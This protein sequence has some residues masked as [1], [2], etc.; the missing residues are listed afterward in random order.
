M[1]ITFQS[2]IKIAIFVFIFFSVA[3]ISHPALAQAPS[4]LKQLDDAFVQ[5]A[6]KVTP[7]VVNIS[8]T[9]KAPVRTSGDQEPFFK[10]FPYRDFFGD[11]GPSPFK[12]NPRGPSGPNGPTRVAMGSGVI[13]SPDGTILTNAHVVKDMDEIKVTLVGKKSYT[14]KVVGIDPPSDIAVIKIDASGLKTATL[15]DSSKLRVGEIVLAVGNPFGLNQTVTQGI[16]S[17]TGRT[18]MGIIDYE[19][20]IQTDAPINPG[21]SGGPLININGEVVGITTAIASSSGGYQGI[22]FAIP[23][24]SAKLISDEIMKGGKVRRGL[25]G[26]NI[27][28]LNEALAKSFG[29]TDVNGALVTSVVP[30]SPA[31]KV[32]IK[33]GDVIVKFDGKNVSGPSELKNLVGAIK[34]GAQAKLTLNRSKKT[35]EVDVTIGEATP[36]T[37][38]AAP[39]DK[40]SGTSNEL[41]IVV[42]KLPSDL[43]EKMGLKQGEGLLVK[44][45]N[46]G[47][48]GSRMGIQEGDVVLEVDGKSVSDIGEFNKE[49]AAAMQN[50]IVRLKIQRGPAVLYLANTW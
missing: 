46:A 2:R 49:V 31:D 48:T 7:A 34:P 23:S 15:G 25:L 40:T 26:V 14:A 45:V 17:A 21:N 3:S 47:E 10:N 18:N 43:A 16:V 41:G 28:P 20:F 22:G 39:S 24:N 27:Q 30:G 35:M 1:T 11:Q 8:S 44:H 42:E 37:V 13:I 9:K 32:G 12:E 38:A 5:V 4:V 29:I 50:K 19:D 33:S 6:E 36:K